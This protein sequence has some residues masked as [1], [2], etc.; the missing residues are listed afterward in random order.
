MIIGKVMGNIWATRK[1]EKLNGL[2]FLVVKPIKA[3]GTF[4][5]PTF[6]AADNVGAGIGDT[7]LVT[8]GSSARVSLDIK[9]APV[10]A[11][12]VGIIDSVEVDEDFLE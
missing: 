5:M 1:D 12:I 10:D 9:D 2:K 7:V 4:D 3:K 8:S 6:V 11:V